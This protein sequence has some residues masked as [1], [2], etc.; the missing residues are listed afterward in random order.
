MKTIVIAGACSGVGK[1][2]LAVDMLALVPGSVHVKIG[3]H[4]ANPRK[5]NLYFLQG[6]PF[7][8]IAESV[9]GYRTVI[10]ESNSILNDLSPDCT[11]Y[12]AAPD[13]KPSAALARAKADMIRGRRVSKSTIA[14]VA[15]NL[16][17]PVRT[18]RRIAW[19]AGA[20]PQAATAIVLAGGKSCR[21]GQDKAM[22]MV[23]GKPMI[24]HVC[25]QLAPWFDDC[26]V[27]T[28]NND[29]R[30]SV[31]T[32]VADRYPDCGPL[33][34]IQACLA[35]S[36]S[37]RNFITSCDIP[38]VNALLVFKLL[39]GLEDGDIS[40]VALGRRKPE[41]L[42]AGYRKRVAVEAERHLKKKVFR[43]TSLF[44]NCKITQFKSNDSRW[45]LNMNTPEEYQRFIAAHPTSPLRNI[46]PGNTTVCR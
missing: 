26:I 16:D 20:R 38:T 27:S 29:F 18:I 37:D 21:M 9:G 23:E 28:R 25:S 12:L 22:L 35:A 4:A 31:L 1:T 42:F 32:T 44:D 8:T 3:H 36:S 14:R 40:L 39:A 45:Y 10:V 19:L 11:I 13:P 7:S 33:G 2:T 43:V 24:D 15:H 17:L 6:T 5:K 34:G 30:T 46:K 41:P